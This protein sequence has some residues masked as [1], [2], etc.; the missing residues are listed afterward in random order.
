MADQSQSQGDVRMRTRSQAASEVGGVTNTSAPGGTVTEPES[1]SGERSSVL[2]Q[3]QTQPAVSL[4]ATPNPNLEPVTSAS[5]RK[6]KNLLAQTSI[7]KMM[8]DNHIRNI[9]A[10]TDLMLTKLYR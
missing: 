7:G 3:N 6:I 10:V 4:S 9:S 2:A 8:L 5:D 1:G